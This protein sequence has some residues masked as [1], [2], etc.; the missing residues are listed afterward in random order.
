MRYQDLLF[1]DKNGNSLNFNY[2]DATQ[3]WYGSM[4]MPKVSTDLVEVAQVFV[5]QKMYNA[6]GVLKHAFPHDIN[7]PSSAGVQGWSMTWNYDLPN[8][9]FFFTYDLSQSVPY[10]NTADE[11]KITLDYDPSQYYDTAGNLHTSIVTDSVLQINVALSS[12]NENIYK[13]TASIKDLMTGDLIAEIVFYGE[14]TGE[15]QRLSVMTSNL[16]YDISNSDYQIFKDSDIEEPLYDQI[17]LNQKK[18]EALLEGSNIFPYTGSY[19]ALLT[20]IKYFGYDDI[21]MKEYWR[22]VDPN[23]SHFGKYLQTLPIELLKSTAVFNDMSVKVP[24]RSLR[25]TGKFGLFYKINEIVPGQYDDYDLPVTK[26]TY[27]YTLEEVLIKLFGLKMKLQ[28]DFLPLNAKIIDIVGEADFFS[29]STITIQPSATRTETVLTG[30]DTSFVS[31]PGTLVFLQDLRTIDSLTFAKNNNLSQNMFIGPKGEPFTVSSYIIGVTLQQSIGAYAYGRYPSA[32]GPLG[33]PTDGRFFHVSDLSNILLAYFSRYA[34]NL[35]TVEQL[36]DNTDIPVGAPI[37]L[38]NTSFPVVTWNS[39]NSYWAQLDTL[40]STSQIFSW[41][42]LEFRNAAE[43]EWIVTKPADSA[44]PSY[45]YTVRGNIKDYDSIPL[46]LP[47]VGSYDVEMR[48][49]D[50]YNNISTSRHEKYV[51][52]KSRNLE[53]LG[54]YLSRK[55]DYNWENKTKLEDYASYWDLPF[56][57]N[58]AFDRYDVSWEMF[59]RGNYALNNQNSPYANFTIST[60]RDNDD[61]SFTGPFFWNNLESSRWMDNGHNWWDGT[62]LAGDTPAFFNITSMTPAVVSFLHLEDTKGIV[63]DLRIPPMADMIQ[64]SEWLN[65]TTDPIFSKYVYNPVRDKDDYDHVLYIM[66]LAKYFGPNGDFN[67]VYGDPGV[68]NVGRQE[69]SKN[70]SISWNSARIID[71]QIS[72]DRSTPVVFSFDTCKIS[73]KDPMTATW[74]IKNNTNADFGD[75][76]YITAR[77]LAYLF[78]F[79][80]EYTISLDLKDTNGNEYRASKNFLIIN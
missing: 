5:V 61:Y 8:E 58:D 78:D 15:D 24:S 62:V 7:Q 46:F 31:V 65:S 30:F 9:I 16:G 39:V 80:G 38:K 29:K 26:E 48:L 41:N 70:Y 3:A 40:A 64:L 22:D 1:F 42:Y 55:P 6:K 23:S 60:F 68:I 71:N 56:L 43:I 2:D 52:V 73:G 19:R 79:P 14:V 51:T 45:S 75:D 67:Q 49:Y 69:N 66:C 32:D 13:R 34:P 33:R 57:P 44:S 54:T 76:K 25:K 11:L 18:K 35:K 21:Y 12:P 28:K 27:A 63:H 20:A 47:Y 10:L 50:Y 74:T 72:L 37:V 77:Y 36:P 53:F 17:L 4:Y 59:N